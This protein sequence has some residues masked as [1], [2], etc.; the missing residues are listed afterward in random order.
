[1]L[2]QI[3]A[4]ISGK[5]D[6]PFPRWDRHEEPLDLWLFEVMALLTEDESS[7]FYF[8]KVGRYPIA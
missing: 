8:K 6:N 1:M 5:D 7:D 2:H 4:K 3:G